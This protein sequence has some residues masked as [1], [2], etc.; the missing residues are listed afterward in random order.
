MQYNPLRWND[1]M[2]IDKSELFRTFRNRTMQHVLDK[3]KF[4]PYTGRKSWWIVS[5]PSIVTRKNL[6]IKLSK[7]R[8]YVMK[9]TIMDISQV[10]GYYFF[11][12]TKYHVTHLRLRPRLR[13]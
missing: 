5:E 3:L 1:W 2:S 4:R 7:S 11:L 8:A 10:I 13:V 6:Y 12:S 9:P